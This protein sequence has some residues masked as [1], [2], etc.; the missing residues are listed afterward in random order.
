VIAFASR[1]GTKR[2]LAAL[3]GAGWGLFVSAAG[4]W[5][6][7]GFDLVAGDNGA[8]TDHQQGLAFN[9]ERFARFVEW[10][11]NRPRLLVLPD[12]VMGGM[13]SLAMSLRW[14]RQLAS[15]PAT[16]LIAVQNG[17]DV[18]DVAAHVSPRVGIA[19]GGDTAWKVATMPTWAALARS[20]GAHCHVL[21]VNTERRIRLCAAAAVDS[22]DG[23]SASR[24]AVTLP[25][26]ELARQQM[27]IEGY[28]ARRA[29]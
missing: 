18:G 3:S 11:G 20:R 17:M 28:L 5:R 10:F 19:V 2:N 9:E 15:H 23:S 21:R 29:A 24:F 6:D 8:W 26:L 4:V 7:E 12:I 13:A 1:T 14:Q 25:P 27:D 22:F 16:L